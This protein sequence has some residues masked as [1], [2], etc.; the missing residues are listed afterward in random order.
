MGVREEPVIT[1]NKSH[2]D[3]TCITFKPDLKRFGMDR[4]DEDIIALMTKRVY[5]LAGVTPASVKVKLN[6]KAIDIKNFV[7]YADLYLQTKD[8]AELPKI[9]ERTPSSDRWEVICSLS[10]G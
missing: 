9:I 3:Y 2:L 7:S 4:L 8:N 6:E 10:D 5:D 1:D